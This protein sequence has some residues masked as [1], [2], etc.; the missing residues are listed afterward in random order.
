MCK[1]SLHVLAGSKAALDMVSVDCEMCSTAQGLE[2]TRASLVD[3]KGQVLLDELVLPENAITDYHTQFSGITQQALAAVTTNLADIQKR[4]C[5]FLS[6]ETLLVGHGLENDLRALR[7]IHANCLDT[8]VLYPHPK[9]PPCKP[10]LR[11]LAERYLKRTIQQGEHDS[12]V[13]ASAA[14]D[15]VKLKI[16]RGPA[17]G[18]YL[19]GAQGDKLMDVLHRHNKRCTLVD[20]TDMLNRHV[21]AGASAV[22]A[23][24][25]DEAESKACKEIA[26]PGTDFV[27][28]Q[29][30]SLGSFLGIR[31]SMKQKQ[32]QAQSLLQQEEQQ[33]QSQSQATAA[34][35]GNAG[36]SAAAE[37]TD[38]NTA[39]LQ[40]C[41]DPSHGAQAMVKTP[42]AANGSTPDPSCS[43]QPNNNAAAN[44]SMR[45]TP[46][47]LGMPE[48][49]ATVKK[50]E[51]V[52]TTEEHTESHKYVKTECDGY[53]RQQSA[54]ELVQKKTTT[55]YHK[56]KREE[57]S[58][59]GGTNNSEVDG[60]QTNPET[61]ASP[62]QT[63]GASEQDRTADSQGGAAQACMPNCHP[64]GDV[65]PEQ[66]AQGMSNGDDVDVSDE[67]LNR[68]L[69]ELD[70]RIGSIIEALPVNGLLED[71][72]RRQAGLEKSR[73]WTSAD[74]ARMAPT[75]SRV[76]RALCFS[77]VKL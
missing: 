50:E 35:E 30:R 56:R 23:V 65:S 2:L 3:S 48:E 43:R 57:T 7:I 32:Q 8:S 22:V 15:L 40:R 6:A 58:A 44:G 60:S 9:G 71:K 20:R 37:P 19:Q 75:A 74:E 36:H 53:G 25:D 1:I 24:T 59:S 10:A 62:P 72:L 68:V 46:N 4:I 27:W 16:A 41:H 31:E 54:S 33:A 51:A 64:P 49:H 67:Q 34:A 21:T 29:L 42:D 17:F 45:H 73:P 11:V 47:G 13:D 63:S 61:P 28:T 66:A 14:L 18:T 76:C 38:T 12:V 39:G 77:Y 5:E 70:R 55:Q 26:K 69:Q 52:S